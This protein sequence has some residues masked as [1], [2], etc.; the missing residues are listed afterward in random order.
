MHVAIDLYFSLTQASKMSKARYRSIDQSF[1]AA[2]LHCTSAGTQATTRP[3]LSRTLPVFALVVVTKGRGVFRSSAAGT[4]KIEAPVAFWLHPGVEHSYAPDIE[5][6]VEHW[7]IFDGSLVLET[8]L[9][10]V[11]PA[12]RP[13]VAIVQTSVIEAALHNVRTDLIGTDPMTTALAGASV[14]RLLLLLGN[15]TRQLAAIQRFDQIVPAIE[16]SQTV[17]EI[18]RASGVAESSLRRLAHRRFGSSIKQHQMRLRLNQAKELLAGTDESVAAI[19][20][21]TG[22]ADAYYFSR[23]F[24]KHEGLAPTQ[25]RQIHKRS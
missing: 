4:I 24:R 19:A 5:G 1:R 9:D 11:P 25:F 22:F 14:L 3:C 17:A 20:G 10:L 6:W 23:W 16:G 18:A 7:A 13:T 2:P 21:E 12:Q 8:T 15:Q